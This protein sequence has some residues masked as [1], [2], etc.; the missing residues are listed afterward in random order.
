MR[1][2]WTTVNPRSCSS[3]LV[4]KLLSR[5]NT[6]LVTDIVRF[7]HV[8]YH[9]IPWKKELQSQTWIM[10]LWKCICFSF[11]TRSGEALNIVNQVFFQQMTDSVF[12]QDPFSPIMH[13]GHVLPMWGSLRSQRMLM[14]SSSLISPPLVCLL[15]VHPGEVLGEVYICNLT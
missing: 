12:P 2:L 8:P 14:S 1:A 4:H 5:D 6:H 7:A 11:H 15:S 13:T 10:L 9:D 3:S